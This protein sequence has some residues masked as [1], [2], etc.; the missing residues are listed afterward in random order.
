LTIGL[1]GIGTVNAVDMDIEDAGEI[2]MP[3]S[4]VYQANWC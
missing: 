2:F 4:S 3:N 1:A